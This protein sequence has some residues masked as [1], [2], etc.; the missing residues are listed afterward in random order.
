M[1]EAL[2]HC[3]ENHDPMIVERNEVVLRPI[4]IYLSTSRVSINKEDSQRCFDRKAI[5]K[6]CTTIMCDVGKRTY[7]TSFTHPLAVLIHA[8]L[9]VSLENPVVGVVHIKVP[10]N[11]IG[12]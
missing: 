10:T 1:G 12:M 9:E 11:G 4:K 3:G 6:F 7:R 8:R 2:P 5:N